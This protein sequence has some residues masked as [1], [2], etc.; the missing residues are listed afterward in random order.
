MKDE[1][2]CTTAILG[3]QFV[4]KCQTGISEILMLSA[5][6]L[7]IPLLLKLGDQDSLE[8]EMETLHFISLIVVEQ[9]LV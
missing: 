6:C 7:D 3:D 2:S 5:G 1:L 8:E 4:V 9:N